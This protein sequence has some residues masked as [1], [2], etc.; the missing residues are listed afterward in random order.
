MSDDPIRNGFR[1]AIKIL[2]MQKRAL[3]EAGAAIE[4]VSGL[5]AIIR[6][7]NR[8]PEHQVLRLLGRAKGKTGQQ[9]QERAIEA[10]SA[11]SLDDVERRLAD[12]ETSRLEL[13]ALAIGRFHVP[14]GS[15]RSLRNISI[16]RQKLETLVQNERMHA[17]IADIAGASR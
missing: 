8:M 5:E 9:E 6:H 2:D 14:R 13:E 1:A 16:L 4:V 7:L 15:M 12:E 11:L 3:V 10:A 17:T